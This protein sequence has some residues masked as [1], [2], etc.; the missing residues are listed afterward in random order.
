MQ[1]LLEQKKAA[2]K[3]LNYYVNMKYKFEQSNNT[4][5][6]IWYEVRIPDIKRE[7]KSI[8]Y[9]IDSLSKLK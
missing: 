9:S 2:E 1:T 7:I 6:S 5:S 4:D 3:T 8:E